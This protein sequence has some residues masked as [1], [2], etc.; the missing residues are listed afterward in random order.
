MLNNLF[1]KQALLPDEAITW[2]F[3][4]FA[5]ALQNFGSDVFD[6]ETILVEPSNKC[7]PGKGDNIDEMA[8]LILGHVKKFA[9]LDYLPCRIVNH[10]EF[11]QAPEAL[12]NMQQVM[13]GLQVGDNTALTLLYEPQQVGNPNAMV[14]NYAHALAYHLGSLAQS[15]APCDQEQWPHMMELL[16]VTMGFGI[17]FANTAHAKVNVGCGSCNNP[18]MERQG[19]LDE[20][21]ALYA[22]AIFCV[23]KEVP[24]KVVVPHLKR[25]LRPLLKKMIKDV[26][27]RGDALARLR[28]INSR[29]QFRGKQLGSESEV[30]LQNLY[31]KK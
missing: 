25:Y 29:A 21:E 2:L 19:A 26:E 28:A 14:A 3:D 10:R 30:Y 15:P 27:Q 7:F 1:K 31:Q 17:M 5:W 13:Q 4:G 20:M 8:Q 18:A 24:A 22:L 9:G 23:L 16:A 12:A 6:N 11:N